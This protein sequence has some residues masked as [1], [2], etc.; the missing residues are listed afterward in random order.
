[1]KRLNKFKDLMVKAVD[2]CRGLIDHHADVASESHT[3]FLNELVKDMKE[4]LLMFNVGSC[5]INFQPVY[6]PP[7]VEQDSAAAEFS[8]ENNGDGDGRVC[9]LQLTYCDEGLLV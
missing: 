3:S 8:K 9:D 7:A 4:E 2:G 5:T 6:V 1:M